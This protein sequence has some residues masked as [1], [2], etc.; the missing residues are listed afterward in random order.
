M[1]KVS[2]ESAI[3]YGGER[4]VFSPSN[5]LLR[6][7]D[8]GLSPQTHMSVL[9][10][11]QDAAKASQMD[12]SAGARVPFPALAYIIAEMIAEAGGDVSEDDVHADIMHDLTT[13]GGAELP[14]LINSVIETVSPP[15]RV[16]KN[17]PA[18]VKAGGKKKARQK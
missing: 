9:A 6:R 2:R 1:A 15:E 3:E 17:S 10:Q 16:A 13:N 7:I 8:A 5:R 12:A 18:P 11:L 4:Y 14:G